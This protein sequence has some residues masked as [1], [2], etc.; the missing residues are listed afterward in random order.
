MQNTRTHRGSAF[1][2]RGSDRYD[3]RRRDRFRNY[4]DYR[5]Y[6][7]PRNLGRDVAEDYYRNDRDNDYDYEDDLRAQNG[8]RYGQRSDGD[9]WNRRHDNREGYNYDRGNMRER[10]FPTGDN[11]TY[12]YGARFRNAGYRGNRQWE[13]ERPEPWQ[14]NDPYRRGRHRENRYDEPSRYGYPG[15]SGNRHWGEH[16]DRTPE[17]EHSQYRNYTD[18]NNPRGDWDDN[19]QRMPGTRLGGNYERRRRSFSSMT[20]N[21]AQGT[22][23]LYNSW[24]RR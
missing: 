23:G 11:Y 6:S 7:T 12:G 24:R 2:E 18:Y 20:G 17:Q 4:G 1:Q 13:T 5:N 21:N 3:A 19:D 14:G 15:Y 16:S 22:P 9:Y 8:N 10:D